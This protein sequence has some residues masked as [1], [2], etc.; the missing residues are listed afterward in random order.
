MP[1]ATMTRGVNI[2]SPDYFCL[3]LFLEAQAGIFNAG[4]VFVRMDLKNSRLRAD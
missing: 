2:R 4:R 1:S 3:H